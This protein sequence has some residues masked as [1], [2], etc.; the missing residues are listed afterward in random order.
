[1]GFLMRKNDRGIVSGGIMLHDFVRNFFPEYSERAWR[2]LIPESKMTVKVEPEHVRVLFACPGCKKTDF[3]VETSRSFLTVKVAKRPRVPAEEGEKHYSC[4]ER[5][6]E[7][8]QESTKLPVM[9]IPS[10]AKAKYSDG[11]LEITFPRAESEH[12]AAKQIPIQ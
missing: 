10:E 6:W 11:I 1:M 5:S 4:C 12:S 2:E 7:E 9:V 8:Y 3:Q